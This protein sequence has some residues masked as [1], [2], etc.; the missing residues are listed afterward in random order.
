M[1]A[2]LEVGDTIT[3]VDGSPVGSADD[4]SSVLDRHDADDLVEL[5]WT[6]SQGGAHSVSVTLAASP[7]A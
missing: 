2:G 3:G 5:T 4:L 1:A 6:D 7:V